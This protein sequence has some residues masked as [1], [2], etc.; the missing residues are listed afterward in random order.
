MEKTM[1][2]PKKAP[3]TDLIIVKVLKELPEKLVKV[4]MHTF[5]GIL[6]VK[7]CPIQLKTGQVFTIPALGKESR[8]VES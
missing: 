5:S 4:L 6:R 1:L 8:N 3:G 7:Y 2:N